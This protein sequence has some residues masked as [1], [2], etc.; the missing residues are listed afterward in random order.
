MALWGLTDASGSAPKFTT[1][2]ENGDKGSDDFGVTVFGVDTEESLAQ[3]AIGTPVSPGW[4]SR[5][6]GTGGRAGRVFQETLVAMSSQGGIT[7]DAEDVA[8]PDLVI[9]ILTQ[10]SDA[11]ANSAA[12]EQATFTVSTST[13]P[14]GGTVTYLWQYTTDAGNTETFATTAAVTGFSGQTTTTL[15]ADANT[16]SDGTLVRVV[17]SATGADSVTSSAATLTV[18]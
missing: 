6:T 5:T 2:A 4:V 11:S 7:T 14:T 3:R 9:Q 16:I 8:F 13:V 15:T 18:S 10:P 17:V 1:S 12:D